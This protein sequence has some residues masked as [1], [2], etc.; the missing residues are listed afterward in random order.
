MSKQAKL[1]LHHYDQLV[2]GNEALKARI[3][4]ENKQGEKVML[5]CSL[6]L[7]FMYFSENHKKTYTLWK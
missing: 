3:T 5:N 1:L 6:S 2:E 7:F 4:E